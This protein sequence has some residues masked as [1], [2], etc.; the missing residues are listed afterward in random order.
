MSGK[1]IRETLAALGVIASMVFVGLEIRQNTA[2]ARAATRH[3]LT[4]SSLGPLLQVR[5]VGRAHPIRLDRERHVVLL[6]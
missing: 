1:A 2:L 3:A 4:D 6:P 5:V